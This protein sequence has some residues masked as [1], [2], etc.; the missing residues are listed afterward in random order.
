MALKTI[1]IRDFSKGLIDQVDSQDIGPEALA[2][3]INFDVLEK[4]GKL[5]ARKEYGQV[6]DFPDEKYGFSGLKVFT[7]DN[8]SQSTVY[9]AG[10]HQGGSSVD[11][12]ATILTKV[13]SEDWNDD[14]TFEDPGLNGQKYTSFYVVIRQGHARVFA[15]T[16]DSTPGQRAKFIGYLDHKQFGESIDPAWT[17]TD[18]KLPN[19]SLSLL[20]ST[21][22][23]LGRDSTSAMGIPE[24]SQDIGY[25]LVYEFL[26]YELGL[27][28]GVLYASGTE[29]N[30][31]KWSVRNL[32]TITKSSLDERVTGLE[33]YRSPLLTGGSGEYR[34][35]ASISV[36]DNPAY[37]ISSVPTVATY[38]GTATKITIDDSSKD[39]NRGEIAYVYYAGL[40]KGDVRGITDKNGAGIDSPLSVCHGDNRL[41]YLPAESVPDN[42]SG[43][44]ISSGLYG[45]KIDTFN[46]RG[47]GPYLIVNS[48]TYSGHTSDYIIKVVGLGGSSIEAVEDVW[49]DFDPPDASY[50][51]FVFILSRKIPS[52]HPAVSG[53]ELRDSYGVEQEYRN[54]YTMFRVNSAYKDGADKCTTLKLEKEGI[55]FDGT[56]Y[57]SVSDFYKRT[58]RGPNDTHDVLGE[59]YGIDNDIAAGG[60]LCDVIFMRDLRHTTAL[61]GTT[62]DASSSQISCVIAHGVGSGNDGYESSGI[63]NHY[64]GGPNQF[65]SDLRGSD[66]S[67]RMIISGVN[68]EETQVY[69]GCRV[70]EAKYLQHI[71]G[72]AGSG[73]E[74]DISEEMGL[75]EYQVMKGIG[76]QDFSSPCLLYFFDADPSGYTYPPD[77]STPLIS[78]TFD[79][80]ETTV[81]GKASVPIWDSGDISAMPLLSYDTGMSDAEKDEGDAFGLYPAYVNDRLFL[82]R[83]TLKLDP[84]EAKEEIRDGA[85]YSTWQSAAPAH[86]VFDPMNQVLYKVGDSQDVMAIEDMGG[87]LLVFKEASV[88]WTFV[89]EANQAATTS[90]ELLGAGGLLSKKAVIKKD[91]RVFYLAPDGIRAIDPQN[92]SRIISEPIRSRLDAIDLGYK[93]AAQAAYDHVSSS[94]HFLMRKGVAEYVMFVWERETSWTTHSYAVSSSTSLHFAQHPTGRPFLMKET[95]TSPVSVYQLGS[96]DSPDPSTKK[97]RTHHLL[98]AIDGETLIR[99]VYLRVLNGGSIGTI[100]LYTEGALSAEWEVSS[101]SGYQ[102]LT[103]NLSERIENSGYAEHIGLF[104]EIEFETAADLVEVSSC[105]LGYTASRRKRIK[106]FVAEGVDGD[107]SLLC[108]NENYAQAGDDDVGELFHDSSPLATKRETD[109]WA[110]SVWFKTSGEGGDSN[111]TLVSLWG[112]NGSDNRIF[113][114]VDTKGGG[115]P[116]GNPRFSV[117]PQDEDEGQVY[118]GEFSVSDQEWHQLYGFWRGTGN[119]VHMYIDGVFQGKSEPISGTI[120]EPDVDL[121]PEFRRLTIG[122]NYSGGDHFKGNIDEVCIWAGAEVPDTP[123]EI[124]ELYNAGVPRD[125]TLSSS[126]KSGANCSSHVIGYWRF[127]EGKGLLTKDSSGVDYLTDLA[128]TSQTLWDTA[129]PEGDQ[130]GYSSIDMTSGGS[131][132]S[133]AT[134][135]DVVTL[136]FETLGAV[137]PTVTIAGNAVTPSNVAGNVWQAQ[138][139]MDDSEAIGVLAFTIDIINAAGN[140]APVATFTT[141]ENTVTYS[142]VPVMTPVTIAS[143]GSNPAEAKAGDVISLTFTGDV[144]LTPTVTIGG[145]APTTITNTTG[146]TWVATRTCDGTETLG[147]IAFTIDATDA[148]GH[149]AVQVAATTDASAVVI[150]RSF[151]AGYGVLLDASTNNYGVIDCST[152]TKCRIISTSN[153]TIEIWVRYQTSSADKFVLARWAAANSDEYFYLKAWYGYFLGFTENFGDMDDEGWHQYVF[154][155]D[156]STNV[157][158]C[159]RDG[160]FSDTGS[161][162]TYADADTNDIEIGADGE[163][164]NLMHD[165]GMIGELRWW[166]SKLTDSEVAALSNIGSVNLGKQPTMQEYYPIDPSAN[167]GNY[168]SS[169]NLFGW[170]RFGDGTEDGSGTTIYNMASGYS[171][172]YN[173]TWQSAPI[174][175]TIG[176]FAPQPDE[177][178]VA[179]KCLELDGVDEWCHADSITH[180]LMLEDGTSD[181]S[182]QIWHRFESSD[183]KG[184]VMCC[185]Y[186]NSPVVGMEFKDYGSAEFNVKVGGSNALYHSGNT[187]NPVSKANY[188]EWPF[189]DGKW[190]HIVVTYRASDGRATCYVNGQELARK[191]VSSWSAATLVLGKTYGLTFG[192]A[193]NKYHDGSAWTAG[194]YYSSRSLAGQHSHFAYWTSLL[195]GH[196]VHTLY[197]NL[198]GPVDLAADSGSYESS[199]SLACW[200][201]FD[202]S[203]GTTVTDDSSNS[204]SATL[205][206]T[207]DTNWVT[208]SST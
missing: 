96:G 193:Y 6:F 64:M 41:L 13:G 180:P 21:S 105:G 143:N 29:G 4:P 68:R 185:G 162:N 111:G 60:T 39:W 62:H 91:N 28:D 40:F 3:V 79:W 77:G 182:V 15:E 53:I 63:W 144:A 195:T 83:P 183:G 9:I 42:S 128:L 90:D 137:T 189:E 166:D 98:A 206:N 1:F 120:N 201:K 116:E 106:D 82:G 97:F 203:S 135:G 170:W 52:A 93:Q 208:F 202:Q 25:K 49:A 199:S 173:I 114:A 86:D 126:Y 65:V 104:H 159:F 51:P 8:P 152:A 12:K 2:E 71:T 10:M 178:A 175:E 112:G 109:R 118:P 75:D 38:T 165:N 108:A 145:A 168:V 124:T 123:N 190:A 31:E 50:K 78:F 147:A 164:A 119:P 146:N 142:H 47:D 140:S 14:L 81:A 24:T 138:R 72:N 188:E 148:N 36:K 54:V 30:P 150:I 130:P 110:M 61:P 57:L 43:L 157:T 156:G 74:G 176:P 132:S 19:P 7:I 174:Y 99:R 149:V 73:G 59:G 16:D 136:T 92:G 181:F 102:D 76:T 169:S 67:P 167:S 46:T 11:S 197:N 155:H 125:M 20:A 205:V 55:I 192:D 139:T 187:T 151:N 69:V 179:T 56:T 117:K 158:R 87:K 141:T 161:M 160:V 184:H 194:G 27:P 44:T 171:T 100:R 107:F 101:S 198:T 88:H 26:G 37:K 131:S 177:V 204:N 85:I 200:Y 115:G 18:T 45:G 94:V 129:D 163:G 207:D 113:A 191:T 48:F 70:N 80:D 186:Y 133:A 22:H 84:G 23:L 121:L 127:N 196:E 32:L 58:G 89:D 154:V 34:N 172:G 103:L 35:T 95:T 122:K 134:V 153:F 66:Y 17:L 5:V 33:L